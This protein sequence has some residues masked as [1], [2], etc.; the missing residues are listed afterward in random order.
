MVSGEQRSLLRFLWWKDGD[1]NN[2][3]IDHEMGRH[4][5]VG[6]SSPSC[7][8]YALKNRDNKLK[9]VLEAAD[10]LNNNFYVD[11]ML[12][13]AASV[14][15]AITLVKNVR[16]LCRAGG[17]RLT[18]F[19]SNSK[20]LL[21]S[22]SQRDRRQEAPDKR[23]LETISNNERALGVLWNIEGDKLGFQIHMKEKPLIRRGMLSQL[24][25]IYDPLGLAAPFMLEG[26]CH[27]NLSWDEQIPDSITRHWPAWKSN[28]LLLEGVKVEKRFK[29]KKFGKIREYILHHFPDAL[30][31]GYRFSQWSYLRLVD[32]NF[33]T[34]V[35]NQ[36]QAIKDDSD[37]AQWQYVPSKSN[38]ADYGPRDLKSW[39]RHDTIKEIDIDDSE[40][41]KEV[42]VHR[43]KVKPNIIE[44]LE[45]RLSSWNKMRRVFVLVLKFKTN[46]LKKDF[47]NKDKAELQWQIGTSEVFLKLRLL[48]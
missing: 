22:V 48:L 28:L 21:M 43:I 7:S 9:Y 35:A 23:L 16:D 46:L 41:H 36:I 15:E 2:P 20:D 8:N 6:F 42:F 31:Y 14:L 12:K 1:L 13:S 40:T 29:P 17:F 39:K 34:F 27:Q 38:P 37:A 32:E 45:T 25:L 11:D 18:K 26:F 4:V 24:S 30:E 3:L 5:F 10:T 47:P 33:K 19:V 44:T